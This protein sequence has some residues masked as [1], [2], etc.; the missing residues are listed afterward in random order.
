MNSGS[1]LTHS[2]TN[3]IALFRVGFYDYITVLN[4]LFQV[5]SA[6]PFHL[7]PSHPIISIFHN[8]MLS[9]QKCSYSRAIEYICDTH[10]FGQFSLSIALRLLHTCGSSS[11]PTSESSRHLKSSSRTA[12]QRCLSSFPRGL[13]AMADIRK[14]TLTNQIWFQGFRGIYQPSSTR[15]RPTN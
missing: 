6:K 9:L 3:L 10:E 5:F 14:R 15:A 2:F 8:K 11:F 13:N 1:H 7:G 4:S 12:Q